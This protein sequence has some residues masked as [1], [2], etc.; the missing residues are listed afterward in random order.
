MTDRNYSRGDIEALAR[1][2]VEEAGGKKRLTERIYNFRTVPAF[3]GTIH[4]YYYVHQDVFDYSDLNAVL[5]RA[6]LFLSGDHEAGT[7]YI[8]LLH[9]LADVG[10]LIDYCFCDRAFDGYTLALLVH[11]WL[12]V[13]AD[14]LFSRMGY[15]KEKEKIEDW[16]Y[17]RA[18]LMWRDRDSPAWKTY[19]PY[20]NQEIGIGV[21][22][23]LA[24]LFKDRDPA[25]TENFHALSDSRLV[26][27]EKKN[28]NLDDTLFYTPVF[29]KV[30]WFYA[31]YRGREDLLRLENCR[32][33]FE[34]VL[35]QQPGNGIFMLYNWT[36]YG[37]AA[38]MMALGASLFQDGRYKW[39]AC[40]FIQERLEKRNR[41]Q[42]YA[43]RNITTESL[44]AEYGPEGNK[45]LEV[46]IAEELSRG[47]RYDH[48]W[49]GLTDNIFHLWYFWDDSLPP[50]RPRN[51]G[52]ALEKTAGQGRWPH[53][54]EPVLPDKVVFREG[55]AENDLF[56][57]MN[58]WGGQNSPAG[59]TVSHRYP[60]SNEIISLVCGEQF[61]TQNI[62][63]ITRDVHIHRRELNAFCLKKNREWLNAAQNG[64]GTFGVYPA[65]N[66]YNAELRF[67]AAFPEVEASKS[68]L[69]DYH[70]WTNER[71]ILYRRGRYAAVFDQCFGPA[72]AEGG[73]RWHLQGETAE[74]SADSFAL[75]L[76]ESKIRV[77]YPHRE[78]WFS[79][80]EN[81]NRRNIA[82]Y[83]HHADIDLD[84]ISRG[85]RMGFV[86]LFSHSAAI[87]ETALAVDVSCNAHPAYPAAMGVRMGK[88][89]IGVR[90]GQFRDDY[91]YD[92]FK[93]DAESFVYNQEEGKL[94]FAGARLF[95]FH[96]AAYSGMETGPSLNNAM[97]ARYD[98]GQILIRFKSPQTGVITL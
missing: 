41:R 63:Q 13:K 56:M 83:Q 81:P 3:P 79:V 88:D 80:E 65:L 33:S 55:W 5:G 17:A 34:N 64:E 31:H 50:E 37:S 19:R 66:L 54:P 87:N 40:R 27:W 68:T 84:L 77:H 52:I 90:L 76:L 62:N 74:R 4:N 9:S 96:L 23:V 98:Q 43:C 71:T 1:Q 2:L 51:Y 21:C 11:S 10:Y 69:Y 46:V 49:E 7:D 95:R 57:I 60:A 47:D 82:V 61:L 35:Q 28:G 36:Q 30:M 38:D 14:P 48:V 91:N 97:S 20:D 45:E 78:G 75:R 59:E 72:E 29:C 12:I 24:E 8:E 58:L 42:R 89:L 15:D 44:A 85:S 94:I 73:V 39:M 16:F 25:L 53:D 32:A 70:G 86:T 22:T 6:A 26:G 67:F 93:T 18:Q 92:G